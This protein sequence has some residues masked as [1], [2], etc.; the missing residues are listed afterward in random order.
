M[1]LTSP[2]RKARP[3]SRRRQVLKPVHAGRSASRPWLRLA[4]VWGF[5]ACCQLGL[6]GRLVWLQIYQS[7]QLKELA[8]AQQR[9]KL[10]PKIGRRPIVDR[11]GNVLAKDVASFRLFLHPFLFDKPE[12]E[13]AQALDP[14]LK[15]S[16]AS[17]LELMET[18]ESGIPIERDISAETAAE[19]RALNLNGVELNLEWQRIYPQ[20]DLTSDVVGYVNADH[21]GQTGIEYSQRQ[22]L[23]VEPPP[24]WVSSDAEGLLLPEKFPIRPLGDD[25]LQVQLTLDSRIQWAARKALKAKITEFRAK[26]GAVIVMDV[27]SGELLGLVTQPSFDP[28]RFYEADPS[29]FK[30]WAVSDLYEPGSTFKPINVAIA[31]ELGAVKANSTVYDEG[32]IV[33]GGW[34]IQNNDRVARGRLTMA[35]VLEYSS[36]VGMVRIIE[37]LDRL[38]Y[39]KFLKKLGIGAITATD[40]PFETPGQVKERAQFV[41][42][43]I[44]PATTS[45]GQ[46]FSVTPLQ[47]AQ[48]HASLANGGKLVTPH[49]VRGVFDRQGR[50]M[51]QP[52]RIGP[53]RVFS[54]EVTQAVTQ[55]MGSVVQNGTGKSAQIPGYRLG[56]KTGTAQKAT[57]GGY[58]S[59]RITSF[60]ST[61]PL[62]K[63]QYV[64]FAVV[65]E[66]QGWHAYGSTVAAPIVKSVIEN[67]ISIEKIPPSHPEEIQVDTIQGLK[68]SETEKSSN[69]ADRSNS[70]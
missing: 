67:L 31:M 6:I 54:P 5:L 50:Q 12:A 2:P 60:V 37:K 64:I 7:D 29:Q 18:A 70:E 56:G 38:Q 35:Q 23:T 27:H 41:D 52:R 11:N 42:Y 14:L 61:F 1:P 24:H 25:N 49:V 44:E 9:L 32:N 55:M 39:F 66:P 69:L 62:E 10:P 20:N 4:L 63:P 36:N 16:E 65:D 47:M 48:L 58:S 68:K 53:R 40:L 45:F 26:R 28:E 3:K 21:E 15:T 19:L 33:V 8:S 34:P 46:G 22:L 30:N 57:A 51:V 59:Q 13:I 43:A 17:L